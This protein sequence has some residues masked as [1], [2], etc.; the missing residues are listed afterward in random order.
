MSNSKDDN[1]RINQMQ[2]P[3][4]VIVHEIEITVNALGEL[5]I[6]TNIIDMNQLIAILRAAYVSQVKR[7]QDFYEQ[8]DD[9]KFK[10]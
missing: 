4:D 1:D 7:R 10:C 9:G 8:T 6:D 3:R 2:D 5:Y